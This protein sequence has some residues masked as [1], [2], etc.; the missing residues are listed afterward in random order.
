MFTFFQGAIV[1]FLIMTALISLCALLLILAL[2]KKQSEQRWI[3]VSTTGRR[4]LRRFLDELAE[5]AR[6]QDPVHRT[7][8]LFTSILRMMACQLNGERGKILEQLQ[9][10]ADD[11]NQNQQVRLT[12][13]EKERFR[14]Y[15]ESPDYEHNRIGVFA[16]DSFRDPALRGPLQTLIDRLAAHPD[17][18]E[19]RVVA[20]RAMAAMAEN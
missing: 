15:L 1:A 6:R 4:R 9:S 16:A 11:F 20:Q 14:S 18:D 17:P 5:K 13:S 7:D 8:L 19:V 3:I 12:S 10:L 2:K